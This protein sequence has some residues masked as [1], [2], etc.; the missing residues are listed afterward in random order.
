M[1]SDSFALTLRYLP[2]YTLPLMP[3]LRYLSSHLVLAIF[4]LYISISGINFAS[5]YP[6]Q[7]FSGS[8][9]IEDDQRLADCKRFRNARTTAL[10]RPA[11]FTR[12]SV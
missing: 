7:Q 9:I 3:N 5:Q 6:T 8:S 4:L 2:S 12:A 10:T 11:L 1:I